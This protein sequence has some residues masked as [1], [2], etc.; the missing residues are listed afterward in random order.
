MGIATASS[1]LKYII[2]VLMVNKNPKQQSVS[3]VEGH[4]YRV[5]EYNTTR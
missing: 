5:V 4:I 2:T 3:N 1:T